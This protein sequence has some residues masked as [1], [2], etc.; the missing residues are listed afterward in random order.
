MIRGTYAVILSVTV[1]L[2]A[3]G[4]KESVQADLQQACNDYAAAHQKRDAKLFDKM[5]AEEFRLI[6]QA[7]KIADKETYIRDAT[8]PELTIESMKAS[9]VE[10]RVYGDAA[11]ETGRVKT[12]IA[13]SEFGKSAVND[14][15]YTDVWIKKDGRWQLVSEHMSQVEE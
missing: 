9:E 6:D 13:A 5:L 15:R 11:I 3:H 7:G 12:A 2:S 4:A 1:V 14:L 8:S 10:L